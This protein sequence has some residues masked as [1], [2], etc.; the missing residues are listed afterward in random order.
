VLLGGLVGGALAVLNF[1]A[2][3][4]VTTIAADRAENQDVE[5]GKKL[6]QSSYPIRMLALAVILFACIKS[7]YFDIL[8]LLLPLIFV[9]ITITV[10]EFFRKKGA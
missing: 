2:I 6:V 7:G 8:A 4:V 5:G 1:F 10:A 9:R 3:A